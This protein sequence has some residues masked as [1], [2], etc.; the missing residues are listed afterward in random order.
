MPAGWGTTIL[1]ISLT[2]R[3]WGVRLHFRPF[4][5]SGKSPCFPLCR[6]LGGH[7]S[8][9]G[10]Y[11]QEENFLCLSEVKKWFLDGPFRSLVATSASSIWLAVRRQLCILK[12]VLWWIIGYMKHS[13]TDRCVRIVGAWGPRW[14]KNLDLDR[15][16][17]KNIQK[18]I[19]LLWRNSPT[20]A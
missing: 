6:R 17:L 16:I 3:W 14:A 10:H 4:Y 19:F 18:D 8:R 11:G 9:S 7:Q 12:R 13:S 20:L 15:G 2:A 1:I 5:P